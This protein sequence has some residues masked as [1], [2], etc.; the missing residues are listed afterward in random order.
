MESAFVAVGALFGIKSIRG[1][2][3]HVVALDADAVEDGADDGAGLERLDG[4]RGMRL[5]GLIWG[6]FSRHERIL[7]CEGVS[8]K[9]PRRHPG[10]CQAHPLEGTIE[11]AAEGY[12][13]S[14]KAFKRLTI[15]PSARSGQATD[16]EKAARLLLE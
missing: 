5:F 6:G 14:G 13:G 10:G 11:E 7:A 15:G 1:H 9:Q 8:S 2:R 12:F 4:C 16:I 3:E